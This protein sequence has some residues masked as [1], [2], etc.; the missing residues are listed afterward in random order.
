MRS[1]ILLMLLLPI[2]SLYGK[3]TYHIGNSHY[4]SQHKTYRVSI[5]G[6]IGMYPVL[7]ARASLY[8]FTDLDHSYHVSLS[9]NAGD[10]LMV[11]GVHLAP[12]DEIGYSI[13][14]GKDWHFIGRYVGAITSVNAGF[15]FVES[16]RDDE[17]YN[18]FQGDISGEAKVLL[19]PLYLFLEFGVTLPIY[20][21]EPGEYSDGIYTDE[22][23]VTFDDRYTADREG[24]A[25]LMIGIGFLI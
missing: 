6:A 10:M 14:F 3:T 5:D 22:N 9:W 11:Q 20:T 7:R 1:F 12:Q 17:R 8:Y 18:N 13:S 25:R 21:Q 24:G 16:E 15:T 23:G 19:G 2:L 4:G